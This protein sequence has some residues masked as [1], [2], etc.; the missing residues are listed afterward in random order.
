MS[1][2]LFAH[3]QDHGHCRMCVCGHAFMCTYIA[4]LGLGLM[5]LALEVYIL[6]LHMKIRM[7]TF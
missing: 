7:H 4:C 1:E 5:W 6:T 2:I 3:L